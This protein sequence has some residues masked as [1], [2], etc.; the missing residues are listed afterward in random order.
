MG[1]GRRVQW[2]RASRASVGA[3]CPPRPLRLPRHRRAVAAHSCSCRAVRLHCCAHAAARRR[4]EEAT[5]STERGR[6]S[7][8]R[9]ADGGPMGQ[10]RRWAQQL[11][12]APPRSKPL[13]VPRAVG[14]AA[15]GA[16]SPQW[17]C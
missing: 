16:A 14:R 11:E 2:R 15:A 13:A 4:R 17:Q 12:A 8:R 5:P 10:V 3:R 6:C 7:A 9:G 1:D